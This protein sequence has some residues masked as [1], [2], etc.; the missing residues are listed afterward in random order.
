MLK[1]ILL[2][3]LIVVSSLQLYGA[4][5]A[6]QED[7]DEISPARLGEQL[8]D[9]D[10]IPAYCTCLAKKLSE[11]PVFTVYGSLV[12]GSEQRLYTV[13]EPL[14]KRCKVLQFAKWNDCRVCDM[15]SAN[16]RKFFLKDG[17]EI[18]DFGY[19][20]D[21]LLIGCISGQLFIR[22]QDGTWRGLGNGIQL[23]LRDGCKMCSLEELEGGYVKVIESLKRGWHLSTWKR[24]P[25]I[26]GLIF[27][28]E[29]IIII[30]K[31]RLIEEENLIK[32]LIYEFGLEDY[33]EFMLGKWLYKSEFYNVEE[34][35]RN[36][37]TMYLA[38]KKSEFEKFQKIFKFHITK[39]PI[40]H[41]SNVI[42]RRLRSER[43]RSRGV[44]RLGY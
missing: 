18:Y 8:K 24:N 9:I 14:V 10:D 13:G 33:T 34:Y 30:K 11:Q 27:K 5:E 4:M 17:W 29:W 2:S 21:K 44:E 37:E 43:R 23:W 7:I 26:P 1:K 39:V 40:Q 19:G 28:N 36:Q 12:K 42:R 15:L 38:I 6:P 41:S 25:D 35:L 32:F 31:K 22:H 16:A 3:A 20:N